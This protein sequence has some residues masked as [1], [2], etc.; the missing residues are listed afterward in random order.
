[1]LVRP[2]AMDHLPKEI[3]VSGKR[4]D[5]EWSPAVQ[6]EKCESWR[7]R[8]THWGNPLPLEKPRSMKRAVLLNWLLDK[9]GLWLGSH[10]QS[11][12][13]TPDRVKREAFIDTVKCWVTVVHPVFHQKENSNEEFISQWICSFFSSTA[14][15]QRVHGYGSCILML[16][17]YDSRHV[18]W[19]ENNSLVIHYHHKF[20]T[21]DCDTT[22]VQVDVILIDFLVRLGCSFPFCL[23]SK[24]TFSLCIWCIT[25]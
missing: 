3:K 14:R 22:T 10:S 12:L 8:D 16:M 4:S 6:K 5:L 11:P 21:M 19:T 1:M 15:L 24:N 17:F 9:A 18:T 23:I 7:K 20:T 25:W 2:G 13:V